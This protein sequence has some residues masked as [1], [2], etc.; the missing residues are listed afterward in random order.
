MVVIGLLITNYIRKDE[1]REYNENIYKDEI[2]LDFERRFG[3]YNLTD[4]EKNRITDWEVNGAHELIRLMCFKNGDWSKLPISKET[5]QQYNEKEGILKDY[6]FTTAEVDYEDVEFYDASPAKIIITNGKEKKRVYVD[7]RFTDDGINYININD[8][9]T[10]VDAN[11][12]KL[13]VGF[14]FDKNHIE[15]NFETWVN[16]GLTDKYILKHGKD[17]LNLFIHY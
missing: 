7:Y 5:R 1:N 15:Q 2:E 16:V 13:N 11:G 12:N 17:L 9:I 4:E 6:K 14:P 10:I 8:V 3:L